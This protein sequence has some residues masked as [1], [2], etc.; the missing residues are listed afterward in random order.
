[1][2]DNDIVMTLLESLSASYEY[3]IT[4]LE[5]MQINE[6]TIEHMMTHLM[7]KMLKNEDKKIQSEM[8]S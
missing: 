3:L 5:T 7:H 1:M 8:P 6:L 2:R 4:A